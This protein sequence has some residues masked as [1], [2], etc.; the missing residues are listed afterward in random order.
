MISTARS[1]SIAVGC[2]SIYAA[3]SA[4][5]ADGA[6]VRRFIDQALGSV[7]DPGRRQMLVEISKLADTYA[8]GFD[9][10]ATLEHEATKL[11]TE[12]LD[13]VGAP[14]VMAPCFTV[15]VTVPV[16]TVEVDVTVADSATDESPY[17]AVAEVTVVDEVAAFTS[18]VIFPLLSP[19]PV[20]PPVPV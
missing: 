4:A 9:K 1:R 7:V 17:V 14:M 11:T 20:D 13:V 16:L 6:A 8:A 15:N 10:L 19:V 5:K 18:C 2:A 12:V 3:E